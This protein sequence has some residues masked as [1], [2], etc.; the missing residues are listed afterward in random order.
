MSEI[1]L[2]KAENEDMRDGKQPIAL[3]IDD[4]KLHFL[5]HRSILANPEARLDP[6][7]VQIVLAHTKEHIDMIMQLQQ[8]NPALLALM[9]E[10]PLP[11]PMMPAQPQIPGQ[12]PQVPQGNLPAMANAQTP[13]AQA[14]E[15]VQPTRMPNLPAG[16]DQNSQE[17]YGKLQQ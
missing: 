13:A 3:I 11:M 6:N 10:Q 2:V 8:T 7:L 17:S 12:Q 9:G 4:H 16:A 14:Q 1:I 5:E 15:N